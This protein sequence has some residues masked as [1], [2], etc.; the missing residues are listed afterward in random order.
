MIKNSSGKSAKLFKTRMNRLINWLNEIILSLKIAQDEYE[1]G[2]NKHRVKQGQNISAD[3]VTDTLEH[4]LESRKAL[5][6][7]NQKIMAA[8]DTLMS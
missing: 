7:R 4:V 2:Q 3:K 1:I 6:E 5:K 8:M